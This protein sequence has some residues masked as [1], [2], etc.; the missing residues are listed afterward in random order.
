MISSDEIKIVSIPYLFI[1]IPFIVMI[2]IRI[3]TDDWYNVLVTSDWSI[4]SAMIYSTCMFNILNSTRGLN[5][6]GVTLNWFI[7]KS[8]VGI[9]LNI[10]IYCVII[11]KPNIVAGIA[12]VILFALASRTHFKY[13]LAA[14]RLDKKEK[15]Q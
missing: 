1:A 13:G 4:A 6:N 10:A 15:Q 14:Y 11:M 3:L 7:V 8:L 5:V 12:Q 2:A 9:S